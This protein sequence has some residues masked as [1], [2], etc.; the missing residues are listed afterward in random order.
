MLYDLAEV[1]KLGL[2]REDRITD[3]EF[4][5]AAKALQHSDALRFIKWW[6]KKRG[7]LKQNPLWKKRTLIIHRGYPPTRRTFRI[8]IV[9]SLA[10]SSTFSISSNIESPE[11]SES[12]TG[13]AISTSE[14][15]SQVASE[16]AI[17]TTRSPPTT[18]QRTV[19]VYFEDFP[20]ESAVDLCVRALRQME[21][22]VEEAEREFNIQL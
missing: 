19:E 18:P 20:D 22:I 21:E 13:N 3:N 7:I 5:V 2:T 6:R 9:E 17:P 8:Y 15:Q 1:W 11:L 10:L 16:S 12:S 14:P 4:S